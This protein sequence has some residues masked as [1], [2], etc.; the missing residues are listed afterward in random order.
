LLLDDSYN[1][2]AETDLSNVE[3]DTEP[4]LKTNSKEID[5]E[6]KGQNIPMVK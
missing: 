2:I 1:L 6:V 5:K 4:V 3:W